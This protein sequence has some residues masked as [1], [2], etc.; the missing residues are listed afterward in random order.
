[1]KTIH[2]KKSHEGKLHRAL[3]VPLDEKIPRS[4]INKAKHSS[5]PHVRAMAN[6]ALNAAKWN[7]K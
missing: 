3:H 6:F 4:K 7:H 2:I 5:D 1:M